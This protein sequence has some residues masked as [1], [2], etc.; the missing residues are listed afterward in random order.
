MISSKAIER[1]NVPENVIARLIT[2]LSPK[3]F[4]PEMNFPKITTSAKN[5]TI[6]PIFIIVVV[7]ILSYLY[8]IKLS[9]IYSHLYYLIFIYMKVD[10]PRLN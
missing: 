1:N 5:A 6:K 2:S 9:T 10:D 8:I 3:H 4:N 7:S